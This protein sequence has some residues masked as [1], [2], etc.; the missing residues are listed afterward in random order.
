MC[1]DDHF[2]TKLPSKRMAADCLFFD[3]EDC[4]LVVQPTYKATWDVPGGVVEYDES[5]RRAAQLLQA[6]EGAALLTSRFAL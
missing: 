2:T 6:S 5:L 3:N 1:A 4:I